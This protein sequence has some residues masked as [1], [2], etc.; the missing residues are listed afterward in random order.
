[1]R[2]IIQSAAD[3]S[4]PWTAFFTNQPPTAITNSLIISNVITAPR[5]YRIQIQP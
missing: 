1:V 5:Y 2:Q 3:L 4:G